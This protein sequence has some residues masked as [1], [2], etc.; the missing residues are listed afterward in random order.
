MN[1]FTP[2]YNMSPPGPY[3]LPLYPHMENGVYS[4]GCGFRDSSPQDCEVLSNA[5]ID[6]S[7]ARIYVS[8][9]DTSLQDNTADNHQSQVSTIATITENNSPQGVITETPPQIVR[10]MF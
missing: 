2:P 7:D 3:Y 8:D 6:A 5:R 1:H 10:E 9:T 4:Q